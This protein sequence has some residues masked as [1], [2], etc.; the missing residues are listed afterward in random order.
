VVTAEWVLVMAIVAIGTIVGASS[1]RAAFLAECADLQQAFRSHFLEYHL[2][3][4]AWQAG[5]T[6]SS[7]QRAQARIAGSR[8]PPPEQTIHRDDCDIMC[9][10]VALEQ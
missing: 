3:G 4:Q 10:A 1:L 5:G 7:Q 6:G 8:F 2:P 9:D